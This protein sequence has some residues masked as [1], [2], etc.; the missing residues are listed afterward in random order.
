MTPTSVPLLLFGGFFLQS[1]SVPP[2]FIWLK[3]ISWFYYGAENLYVTQWEEAGACFAITPPK[4]LPDSARLLMSLLPNV[5]LPRIFSDR[6]VL[7]F[8][9]RLWRF[10]RRRNYYW[11]GRKLR[12]G[13]RSSTKW[14]WWQWLLPVLTSA[15]MRRCGQTTWRIRSGHLHLQIWWRYSCTIFI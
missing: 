7:E 10:E 11:S 5:S 13:L 14:R 8:R 12:G 3:Y 15:T 2:Y 1:E 4:N 6:T 9:H